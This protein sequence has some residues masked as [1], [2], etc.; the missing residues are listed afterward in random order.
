M[1]H[2]VLRAQRRREYTSCEILTVQRYLKVQR[3]LIL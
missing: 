3:L 2:V 1:T